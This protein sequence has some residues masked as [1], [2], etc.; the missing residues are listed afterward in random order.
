MGIEITTL[1][2][3]LD[4]GRATGRGFYT[5]APTLEDNERECTTEQ[6]EDWGNFKL[7]NNVVTYEPPI[8]TLDAIKAA[9]ISELRSACEAE[10]V[11]GFKSVALGDVHHYPSDIKAQVNLMGSVTDSLVPG[12]PSNWTTPFW[13]RDEAGVW[14]WKMHTAAQIQQAGRDGKANVVAAQTKLSELTATVENAENETS[15]EAVVW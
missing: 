8:A 14:A 4:T 13:V 7:L 11:G 9:R 12:L 10:I 1:I 15:F 3:D 6:Y 2:F 5:Y